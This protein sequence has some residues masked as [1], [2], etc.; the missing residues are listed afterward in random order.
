M[1]SIHTNHV[2]S[3]ACITIF[4]SK[5]NP[6]EYIVAS[7]HNVPRSPSIPRTSSRAVFL[8]KWKFSFNT[9]S[10][11]YEILIK[12]V[13][14]LMILY[15]LVVLFVIVFVLANIFSLLKTTINIIKIVYLK[16]HHEFK[17]ELIFSFGHQNNWKSKENDKS[18]TFT[19]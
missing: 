16:V 18:F 1:Y 17:P 4:I 10:I 6:A 14:I 12:N 2:S 5:H 9:L 8:L 11:K 15:V 13:F 3:G 7:M 19:I